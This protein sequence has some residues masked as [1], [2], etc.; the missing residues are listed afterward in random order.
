MRK[1]KENERGVEDI[2]RSVHVERERKLETRGIVEKSSSLRK[3]KVV[4][5]LFKMGFVWS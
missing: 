2:Y 4:K 1:A 3:R 5:S